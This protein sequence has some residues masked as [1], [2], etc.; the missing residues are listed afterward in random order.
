MINKPKAV[1]LL[2][3]GLDSTTV[4]ALAKQKDFDIYCMSFDYGQRHLQELEAVQQIINHYKVH[5]ITQ[6]IYL[7]TPN[8]SLTNLQL[9]VPKN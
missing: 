2:S 9:N 1:I 3:G 8:S 7:P 6:R 5:S 4:L